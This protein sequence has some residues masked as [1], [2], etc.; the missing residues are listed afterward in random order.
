MRGEK[1]HRHDQQPAG[2]GSPPRARGKGS[3]S[4]NPTRRF[5]ITPACA[6]KRRRRV[7]LGRIHRDHPRVRGEKFVVCFVQP[8]QLGSPPRARGKGLGQAIF[9]R[10]DGIT[11]ACAG[12][13]WPGRSAPSPR[14]D[15]PRVRGEKIQP[16]I[17]SQNPLGITPACAGKSTPSRPRRRLPLGSPPRARGKGS[18]AQVASV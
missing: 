13:R 10:A 8:L 6:G 15:H 4:W 7:R 3:R 17:C 1:L 5:R 2:L 18:K 16:V 12:K 11:P 9:K 14:W